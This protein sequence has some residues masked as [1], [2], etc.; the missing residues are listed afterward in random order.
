MQPPRERTRAEAP[1]R[2]F[3][4]APAVL[5][6]VARLALGRIPLAQAQVQ[7]RALRIGADGL[8]IEGVVVQR[9]CRPEQR[10]GK[11]L[12]VGGNPVDKAS[13]FFALYQT[14]LLGK[15]GIDVKRERDQKGLGTGIA[16]GDRGTADR[17]GDERK[18]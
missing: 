16:T 3:H 13:A 2:R 8:G 7:R 15:P 1:E 14:V 5:A 18:K 17:P 9:L 6:S 12:V 10:C 4:Q 11:V